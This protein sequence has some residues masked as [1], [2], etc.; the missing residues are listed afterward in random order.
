VVLGQ[1]CQQKCIVVVVIIRKLSA[2]S[3]VL[4]V[5]KQVWSKD[6]GKIYFVIIVIIINGKS[7]A[8][9]SVDCVVGCGSRGFEVLMVD[10]QKGVNIVGVLFKSWG[11]AMFWCGL[12]DG[13]AYDQA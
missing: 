3:V 12:L 9:S 1:C 11:G 7:L 5:D 13:V 10:W 6:V 2:L 4:S 8:L